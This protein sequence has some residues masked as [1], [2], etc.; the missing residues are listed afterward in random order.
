MKRIIAAIL[1]LTLSA[2][3]FA[4]QIPKPLQTGN[5]APETLLATSINDVAVSLFIRGSWQ[6]ELIHSGILQCIP[7]VYSGVPLLFKQVP[8]V[9]LF[10]A[11]AE[12]LWFE[13]QIGNDLDKNQFSAGYY[14]QQDDILL[15]IRV[16]NTNISMKNQSFSGLGNPASSFGIKADIINTQNLNH[17]EAM[18]RWDTVYYETYT[19]YGYSEETKLSINPAQWLRGKAFVLPAQAQILSL[20]TLDRGQTTLLF[21][22]AYEYNPQTGIVLLKTPAAKELRAVIRENT[23]EYELTLFIPGDANPLELKNV[24]SI[25]AD[26][27]AYACSVINKD[28]NTVD[29]SYTIRT[30]SA[31]TIMVVRNN[32]QDPHTDDFARPFYADAPWLYDAVPTNTASVFAIITSVLEARESIVLSE[33]VI[34]GS[35]TVY[36]N[37]LETTSFSYDNTTHTLTL[38]PPP[39]PTDKIVIVCKKYSTNRING[40]LVASA[41]YMANLSEYATLKSMLSGIFAV[42][43]DFSL[44]SIEQLYAGILWNFD[45]SY[46]NEH[47]LLAKASCSALFSLSSPFALPSGDRWK[48]AS[49]MHNE[50]TAVTVSTATAADTFLLPDTMLET[51]P[52]LLG[53]EKTASGTSVYTVYDTNIQWENYETI[54]FYIQKTSADPGA[55]LAIELGTG[56]NSLRIETIPIGNFPQNEWIHISIH[57][58][59]GK[60]QCYD[61]HNTPVAVPDIT[62]KLPETAA[63]FNTVKL[64]LSNEALSFILSEPVLY[65]PLPNFRIAQEG[66]L[67]WI[68]QNYASITVQE[69]LYWHDKAVNPLTARGEVQAFWKLG[70]FETAL[71][72]IL[73][74]NNARILPAFNFSLRL[75]PAAIPFSLQNQFSFTAEPNRFSQGITSTLNTR[76]PVSVNAST[77]FSANVIT[78]AW[79]LA[80]GRSELIAI[81]SE[82][83]QQWLHAP[84]QFDFFSAYTDSWTALFTFTDPEVFYRNIKITIGQKVIGLTLQARSLYSIYETLRAGSD[85]QADIAPQFTFAF[86]TITPFI[87]KTYSI[88]TASIDNAFASSINTWINTLLTVF[89]TQCTWEPFFTGT[90]AQS[91]IMMLEQYPQAYF[92]ERYGISFQR[93]L[94]YGLWDLAVPA[95]ISIE[96]FSEYQKRESLPVQKLG[97]TGTFGAK[98]GNIFSQYGYYPLFTAY[99]FDE[100]QWKLATTVFGF[101]QTSSA[102]YYAIKGSLQSY[103]TGKSTF[104][105]V[106]TC[107]FSEAESGRGFSCSVNAENKFPVQ[108]NSVSWITELIRK[109]LPDPNNATT[110]NTQEKAVIS[111]WL[112]KLA[113]AGIQAEDS[114]KIGALYT[115]LPAQ[116]S[117]VLDEY[118]SAESFMETFLRVTFFVKLEETLKWQAERFLFSVGYSLGLSLK[119]VF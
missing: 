94:G 8:D 99:T 3:S 41:G 118:Y 71:G 101:P 54:G 73:F 18:L 52:L 98:A 53:Y 28:T 7:F 88:S 116:S 10:L 42:P 83:K 44:V 82:L 105:T 112:M 25:S 24:Y 107:E 106:F 74:Y 6:A 103:F 9:Y 13:A 117:L 17:A 23:N 113:R 66:S 60:V 31:N 55:Q 104:N 87:N 29:S 95:L 108:R 33:A 110:E 38:T 61:I 20:Y 47:A 92:K 111:S 97:I 119:V 43:E 36:R 51:K 70:F 45:R 34:P 85:F 84:S 91:I 49:F 5:E 30:I 68:Q 89:D 26:T 78:Q 65:H 77:M 79:K 100:Y 19:Y 12:S 109:Q 57:L 32:A 90:Y 102:V 16:G 81:N 21:P 93:P 96:G 67:T 39:L 69:L 22:D 62:I 40:Q 76:F 46:D 37:G 56:T 14:R 59:T 63:A 15:S 11:L 27:S 1:L 58:I 72:S 115:S 4:Q 86:G 114:W 80:A 35:I 75:Q 64:Y 48:P 2:L 50:G